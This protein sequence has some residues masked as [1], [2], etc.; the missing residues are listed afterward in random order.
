MTES[1]RVKPLNHRLIVIDWGTSN[2]RAYLL[3]AAT[4]Q[5]L[6]QRESNQGLMALQRDQFAGY[7][8]SQVEQWREAGAVPL[9]LS[10]MVGSARGWLE[11]PQPDL[12][13]GFAEL[14]Q[15]AIA[16]PELHN[17]WIL[18]GAKQVTD[19]HVDIM[20][21][22]EIQALGALTL[23]NQQSAYC[24]LPGTHSKW[25]Q[26]QQQRITGF[27]TLMTGE[28]YQAVR[29]HTL[30]GEPARQHAPFD[31]RAFA[32]G[33]QR[34]NDHGGLLH[35]LFETRSRS[36]YADLSD[37]QAVSYLSG[38]LI[39]EEVRAMGSQHPDLSDLLLV[40]SPNLREPYTQA[41]QHHRIRVQ[42]FDSASATLAG[43][44]ELF[45][46]HQSVSAK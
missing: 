7:C 41:L 8:L 23:A 16:I 30:P 38:V 14:A 21:G 25:V 19:T 2:F 3:D 1:D 46:H 9:Y 13:L 40:C 33:L 34:V 44:R 6:D 27:T 36:L 24:C 31:A 5:C 17:G 42:W 43:M 12:P 32:L 11:A 18:P 26:L 10:G 20:R 37:S 29:D 28:L 22:E 39:G 15:Q 4:G 35:A 45:R